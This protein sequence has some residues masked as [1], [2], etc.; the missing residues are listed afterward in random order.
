MKINQI[1]H[2]TIHVVFT[3]FIIT[4]DITQSWH[5]SLACAMY[6]S[7]LINLKKSFQTNEKSWEIVNMFNVVMSVLF[8]TDMSFKPN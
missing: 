1:E 3:K 2:K 7:I 5:N 4:A 8:M 6:L